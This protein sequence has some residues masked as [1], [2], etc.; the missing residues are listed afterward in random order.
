MTILGSENKAPRTDQ[1]G[2]IEGEIVPNS[3]A[4]VEEELSQADKVRQNITFGSVPTMPPSNSDVVRPSAMTF[5]ETFDA[6]MRQGLTAKIFGSGFDYSTTE[7]PD[8]DYD[9][10]KDLRDRDLKNLPYYLASPN[11][12]KTMELQE[13]FDNRESD[14]A[15]MSA[16]PGATM[17]ISM[18]DPATMAA[19]LA[20]YGLARMATLPLLAKA[21][22]STGWGARVAA[23][24]L[25]AFAADE[26]IVGAVS[27]GAYV[28]SE[29]TAKE[30]LDTTY[31]NEEKLADA[32]MG[33]VVGAALGGAVGYMGYKKVANLKSRFNEADKNTNGSPPPEPKKPPPRETPPAPDMRMELKPEKPKRTRE[34]TIS[35]AKALK[36]RVG[37]AGLTERAAEY[38]AL[39]KKYALVGENIVKGSGLPEPVKKVAS[40][41]SYPVRNLSAANRLISSDSGMARLGAMSLAR[42]AYELV[43]T[44][45]GFV[46]N[47]AAENIVNDVRNV[48]VDVNL[49]TFKH[50]MQHMGI[51]PGNFQAE[52]VTFG[53]LVE[54]L[55][56]FNE[57]VGIHM[58]HIGQESEKYISVDPAVRNAAQYTFDNLYKPYGEK[59]KQ[60]GIINE[61]EDTAKVLNYLNRMY[62]TRAMLQNP[63]RF[64][65]WLAEFYDARNQEL[66]SIMPQYDLGKAFARRM[67]YD[68]NRFYKAADKIESL[69]KKL[70]KTYQEKINK[71]KSEAQEK[72]APIKD[73]YKAQREKVKAQY[74]KDETPRLEDQKGAPPKKS[75]RAEK[76][77]LKREIREARE[78][79]DDLTKEYNE[80]ISDAN[81]ETRELRYKRDNEI[82]SIKAGNKDKLIKDAFRK[83]NPQFFEPED[84]EVKNLL[85]FDELENV[86]EIFTP[87]LMRELR[88]GYALIRRSDYIDQI[89]ESR[90]A[91]RAL[92]K[93]K[94]E[95]LNIQK[96][97]MD[98]VVREAAS[99]IEEASKRRQK[100]TG[101]AAESERIRGLREK[102]ELARIDILEARDIARLK[103]NIELKARKIQE[104]AD[105]LDFLKRKYSREGLTAFAERKQAESMAQRM[106][107]MG[108]PEEEVSEF[109]K[110][111]RSKERQTI[112]DAQPVSEAR[113]IADE[114]MEGSEIEMRKAEDLIPWELRSSKTGLPYKTWN[115]EEFPEYS[116]NLADNSFHTILGQEDDVIMNPAML[117]LSGSTPSMFKP[118]S[119][120]MADNYPGIEEWVERDITKTANS[121]ASGIA[122]AIAYSEIMQNLN[123]LDIVRQIVQKLN[124]ARYGAEKALD[125][126]DTM[127]MYTEV[128]PVLHTLLL[129]EFRAA[130]RG[131][132]GKPL[133]KLK[134]QYDKNKQDL[135]TLDKQI[136]GVMGNGFNVNASNASDFIDVTNSMI[137]TV[138]NNNIAV[139]MFGEVVGDSI[140]YG[141]L[142]K[143]K[144]SLMPLISSKEL[145]TMNKKELN[146]MYI[147]LKTEMASIVNSH[148]SG[149]ENSI[150]NSGFASKALHFAQRVGNMTGAN[151]MQDLTEVAAGVQAKS[152]LL[153]MAEKA[154]NGTLS[155][156]EKTHLAQRGISPEQ[157]KQIYDIWKKYGWEKET[158]KG[159][160]PNNLPDGLS[161][162]EVSA[163]KQYHGFI[164]DEVTFAI[165]RPGAA[166]SPDFSYSSTGKMV[167]FLKKWFFAAG[168][169][170]F[171]PA[172]QRADQEAIEGFI[173][174]IAMGALQSRVRELYRQAPENEDKEFNLEGAILDAF[175]NAGVL[176]LYTFALDASIAAGVLAGNGGAR[177]DPMNGLPSM[178]T[179]PGVVGFGS[180]A[181]EIM[182]KMRKITTD[183]DRQFNYKD[184][185]HM[186]NVSV[187]FYKFA[188]VA[189]IAKP[190]VKEYFE[191]I[192]RGE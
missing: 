142:S 96:S 162:V 28:Y 11:T 87:G 75:A 109:L 165:A 13:I 115:A 83:E 27:G 55:K 172:L 111:S 20:T 32:F 39:R 157:A 182:G 82:K 78:F 35:E 127:Q 124:V 187:P 41:I 158:V 139:S 76:E 2:V 153:D 17:A 170:I 168:N 92:K 81:K 44:R 181:L 186:A 164:T 66:K 34:E 64:K 132:S 112:K 43:G 85:E 141:I 135:S 73:K 138:T 114:L 169:D 116:Y 38:S 70:D 184:F 173:T 62:K 31:L 89:S 146:A 4:Q 147:G 10:F 59:L 148:M 22:T 185:N 72:L 46:L 101:K 160:D 98:K 166:S 131:L 192:D 159:I 16:R 48:A 79:R 29:E 57:N 40:L 161:P 74:G 21:A 86:E 71:L 90:A 3:S 100:T 91:V 5:S 77:A 144:N 110:Q 80:K 63:E 68:A 9:V 49:E 126:P 176:G 12:Q 178:I 42:T 53:G 123:Q 61:Q 113:T 150:K 177:Y 175:T 167:L 191:S 174:L 24:P 36:E 152:Q 129:D 8:P 25:L 23:R 121:F 88:E 128:M 102:Y 183:E 117:S 108:R 84:P 56:R 133:E 94:K 60:L 103:T 104:P 140:R 134:T 26:A 190:N 155:N 67:R 106:R 69:E 58:L 93:E 188:P 137:S 15:I 154:F 52:R 51:K 97:E 120:K 50:F 6:T 107:D 125:M 1:S 151:R 122:P 30:L 45:E 119:I 54:D 149:R 179:G 189:L 130:S 171:I 33:T 99:L 180:K 18:A 136:R 14:L 65:K 163:L 95:I 19:S 37:K 143:L 47:R 118:R 105:R 156:K 145:Y 7:P